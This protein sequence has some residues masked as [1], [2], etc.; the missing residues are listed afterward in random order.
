MSIQYYFSYGANTHIPNMAER[1]PSAKW[2]G[3]A[4]LPNYALRF[5]FHADVEPLPNT[6][7]LGALWIVDDAAIQQLDL[8]EG[9]PV[10]YKRLEVE[11]WQDGEP[12]RALIYMM[13]DQ[14]FENQPSDDYLTR[15]R[16][17]YNSSKVPT[18]QIDAALERLKSLSDD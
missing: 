10:Y 3:T 5:R 7:V 11:V 13:E 15:C 9:Y 16:E 2:V 1:C 6:N 18:Q 12:I 8:Y 14:T 4:T 17:G